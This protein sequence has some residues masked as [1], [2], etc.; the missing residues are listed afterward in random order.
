M[1]HQKS[2]SRWCHCSRLKYHVRGVQS[3]FLM[4]N[5]HLESEE[6]VLDE[7]EPV[8]VAV[9]PEEVEVEGWVAVAP[10]PPQKWEL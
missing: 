5:I 8:C 9:L 6:L 10:W 1:F 2:R 3:D 7:L 4:G